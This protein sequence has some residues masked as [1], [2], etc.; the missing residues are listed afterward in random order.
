MTVSNGATISDD[1]AGIGYMSGS[2]G[3][4][5]VDGAGSTWT[6]NG[7]ILIGGAG[8]GQLTISNGGSVVGLA[9]LSATPPVARGPC[10]WTVQVQAGQTATASRSVMPEVAA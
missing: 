6:G 8:I 9:G 2:Q 7:Q 4:A 1:F 5:A 3:T 10:W